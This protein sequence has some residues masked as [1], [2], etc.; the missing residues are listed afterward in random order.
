MATWQGLF[1]LPKLATS[2]LVRGYF[3]HY[4]GKNWLPPNQ[5]FFLVCCK[6][7]VCLRP[8]VFVP[9][10]ILHIHARLQCTHCTYK[11]DSQ[12]IYTAHTLHMQG[13]KHILYKPTHA[14][15]SCPARRNRYLSI[16]ALQTRHIGHIVSPLI[17]P[18]HQAR[19]F[20][21]SMQITFH[22]FVL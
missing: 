13:C 1:R 15:T 12:C 10:F 20:I 19:W 8:P 16:A 18:I 3:G 9:V 6:F 2:W 7:V 17:A 5:C 11:A 14:D 21:A 4:F 22:V